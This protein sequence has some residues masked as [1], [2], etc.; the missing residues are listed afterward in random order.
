MEAGRK[1]E[2]EAGSRASN[3]PFQRFFSEVLP[4]A[5]LVNGAALPQACSRGA[6]PDVLLHRLCVCGEPGTVS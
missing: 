1:A 6:P 2:E 4:E 5:S 3:G